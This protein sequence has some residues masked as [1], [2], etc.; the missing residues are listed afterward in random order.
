MD[1]ERPVVF[2]FI[3]LPVTSTVVTT[4][5]MVAFLALIAAFAGTRLQQ[6]A[7]SWQAML[8]WGI[9]A[10]QDMLAETAGAKGATYLPLIATIAVFILAA[11]TMS[12]L[13][14]IEAPTA[15]INTPVALALLVFFAVH[16][17]GIHELG[18]WTYLK[19]FA[20]PSP[21][22]LP[23]NVLNNIT[24]TISLAIR[25]FGNMISHQII[26]AILLLILPLLI[27]A[28]MQ[29]FGLFV[30]AIQAYIFT[31]LTTVYI[32]GAVQAEGEW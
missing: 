3:G 12:I 5:G 11:N 13:P 10:L 16:A 32:S 2:T 25:L 6:R 29:I 24:R 28:I 26:V 14:S 21:L 4:V 22:L 8:E 27:P 20:E 19:K 1:L 23:V 7:A 17:I 9:G 30:G 15:D 31:M 18:L